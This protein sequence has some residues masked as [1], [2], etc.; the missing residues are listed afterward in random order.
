MLYEVI[1]VVGLLGGLAVFD[2]LAAPREAP[3]VEYTQFTEP[4]PVAN[5]T[6]TQPV[7][8][9]EPVEPATPAPEAET[10]VGEPEETAAPVDASGRSAALPPAPQ[11]D[12]VPSVSP[13]PKAKPA[14]QVA[15]TEG[16]RPAAQLHNADKAPPRA[17]RI[18]SYNVRNNFV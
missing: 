12:A 15:A 8:P 4:V 6:A 9:I 11:V 18:T 13:A 14:R 3:E 5:K 17:A 10:T 2:Y 7:L 16:T 1:T